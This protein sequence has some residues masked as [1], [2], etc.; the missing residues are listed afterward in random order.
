MLISKIQ[1][2]RSYKVS[3]K[4]VLDKNL[5]AN[6]YVEQIYVFR[7]IC[8]NFF[9]NHFVTKVTLHLIKLVYKFA[10]SR[11]IVTR[12]KILPHIESKGGN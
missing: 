11:P 5:F 1:T 9:A 7:C 10:I 3:P 2:Y 8:N 12:K 6:L 4:R